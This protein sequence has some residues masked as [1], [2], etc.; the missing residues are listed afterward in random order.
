MEVRKDN[1]PMVF[2]VE[3]GD[4]TQSNSS[5]FDDDNLHICSDDDEDDN[6]NIED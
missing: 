3:H 6:A 1:K 2:D 4:N 5:S